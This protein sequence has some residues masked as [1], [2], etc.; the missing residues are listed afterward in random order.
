MLQTMLRAAQHDAFKEAEF[1]HNFKAVDNRLEI[2]F[3]YSLCK[4]DAILECR[5]ESIPFLYE[6]PRREWL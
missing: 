4:A 5:N 1:L 3:F 2:E 6:A